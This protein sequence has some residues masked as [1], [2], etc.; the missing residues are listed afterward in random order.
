MSLSWTYWVHFSTV[1]HAAW[2]RGVDKLFIVM[3]DEV[4]F[5]R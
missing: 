2:M 1:L 4:L 5:P 3:G